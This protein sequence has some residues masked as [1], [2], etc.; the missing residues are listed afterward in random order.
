MTQGRGELQALLRR[1]GIRPRRALGQHFL[2]DPNT[3]RKIVTAAGKVE[4]R[5]VVEIG[6]GTGTLT[7]ALADAGAEVVA[8]ELDRRLQPVLAEALAGR[9]V[10]VRFEDAASV[11]LAGLTAG[12]GWWLVANLPYHVG[13]PLLL[14]TLRH[15]GGIERWV[16]MVQAEV[17]DRLVARPGD[18]AYGLPSVVVALFAAVEATFAVGATVFVPPPPVRSSVVVLGREAVPGA[19][20]ERAAELAAVAFGQRRKMV[21][22]SLG[23]VVG[24][25]ALE[26][27][28]IDPTARPERLSADEF[29]RLAEVTDAG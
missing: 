12:G 6:A 13:T 23:P 16:V 2:A 14:D 25:E 29:L 20:R 1:H 27:A 8:Y 24:H 19:E 5:R 18:D 7:A 17:A 3:V 28:D 11:D 21:R 22:S 15:A 10:D 26:S 9:D 4:G